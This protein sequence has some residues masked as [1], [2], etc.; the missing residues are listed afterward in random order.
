MQLTLGPNNMIHYHYKRKYKQPR[1]ISPAENTQ[2]PA[3]HQ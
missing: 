3:K 2:Y 1:M